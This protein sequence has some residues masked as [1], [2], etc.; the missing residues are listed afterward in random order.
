MMQ[1]VSLLS[2][3]FL[4]CALGLFAQGAAGPAGGQVLVPPDAPEVSP[5]QES[6]SGTRRSHLTS[7]VSESTVSL[8]VTPLASAQNVAA[9]AESSPLSI[10]SV[11]AG[12]DKSGPM[13][14]I[15][16]ADTIV[17]S[18]A[19]S[20]DAATTVGATSSAVAGVG[21]ANQAA[22][23]DAS[24][25]QATQNA[26]VANQGSTK[27]AAAN[28][29]T[30]NTAVVNRASVDAAVGDQPSAGAPA[31][32]GNAV[33]PGLSAQNPQSLATDPSTTLSSVST[34]PGGLND[35]IGPQWGSGR[36][37]FGVH[38]PGPFG[39]FCICY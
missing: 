3:L 26:A 37:N 31:P 30:Q 23:T 29:A 36:G 4:L 14:E 18:N 9:P 6:P 10:I 33:A 25:N 19:A 16:V 27:I 39:G 1:S 11:D 13:A 22:V 7:S 38:Y 28:E 12:A 21:A 35:R 15:D 2:G 34:P 20:L 17:Q 32:A 24:A 5:P 8:P